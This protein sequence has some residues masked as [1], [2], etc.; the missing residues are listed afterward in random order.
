MV[1]REEKTVFLTKV[2]SISSETRLHLC[3]IPE[4]TT[5]MISGIKPCVS[6]AFISLHKCIFERR[7][8]WL[9]VLVF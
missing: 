9:D 7:S 3:L 6:E 5:G 8:A 1:P 2:D 4:S